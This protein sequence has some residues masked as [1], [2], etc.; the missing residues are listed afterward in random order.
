MTSQ[1]TQ[2][3]SASTSTGLRERTA[4]IRFLIA[5]TVLLGVTVTNLLVLVQDWSTA[6]SSAF[7]GDHVL[8][9]VGVVI[10]LVLVA[11]GIVKF[12]RR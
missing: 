8:Q 6:T 3:R 9:L 10:G 11:V 2:Q 5:G 7:L 4:A 1:P 12:A